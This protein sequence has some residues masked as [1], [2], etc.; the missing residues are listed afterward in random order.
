MDTANKLVLSFEDARGVFARLRESGKRIVQ[1]H[2]TFDL[3][4][5]GHIFH[6]EEAKALGDVLIV[7]VTGEAHVNKGPG[8]PYFNDQMRTKWL[9]ALECVDYVVLVPY[10]AA[11]EAIECV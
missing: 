9:T 6:F 11:V 5:P 2:G 8:R 1:C 7:T 4:H 10:P 3:V